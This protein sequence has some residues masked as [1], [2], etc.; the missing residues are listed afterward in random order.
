M[1][2]QSLRCKNKRDSCTEMLLS[3]LRDFLFR[4]RFSFLLEK[5]TFHS[6]SLWAKLKEFR[7]RIW[8]QRTGLFKV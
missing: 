5:E 2:F 1:L 7:K 3:E 4:L 8:N 6:T